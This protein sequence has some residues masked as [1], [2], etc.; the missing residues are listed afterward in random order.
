V[1]GEGSLCIALDLQPQ[2]F[3]QPSAHHRIRFEVRQRIEQP[4]VPATFVELSE[5]I[6]ASPSSSGLQRSG[7]SV[8][9]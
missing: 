3:D 9:A 1:G 5:E 8:D 4:V 2:V 6:G 7:A